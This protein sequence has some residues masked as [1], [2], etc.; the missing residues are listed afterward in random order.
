M[1]Q[2][3]YIGLRNGPDRIER[4]DPASAGLRG[5]HTRFELLAGS[6]RVLLVRSPAAVVRRAEEERG[7]RRGGNTGGEDEK[8]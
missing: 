6:R 5:R 4:L 3:S 2:R 7:G 1:R 8:G